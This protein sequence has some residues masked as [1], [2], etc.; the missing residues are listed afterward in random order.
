MTTYKSRKVEQ[1]LEKKGFIK[2][3]THHKYFYFYTNDGK[4][5]KVRTYISHGH[6]DID[7]YLIGKMAQQTRL[8]KEQFMKLIDCPLSKEEYIN[9]L[10]RQGIT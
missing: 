8:T 4:R 5:T 1:S 10:K 3:D 6:K 9:I 2:E 7:D